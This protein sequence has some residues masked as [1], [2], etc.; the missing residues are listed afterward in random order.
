MQGF[1]RAHLRRH[2]PDPELRAKLMPDFE[3]ACKRILIS[4]DW[5]PALA[6]DNVD[7]VAA[8]VREVRGRTVIAN[9]GSAHDVDTIIFGTGFEVL[10]PPVAERIHGRG[11]RSLA[12]AWRRGLRHYRAVE[13]AGFPQLLPPRRRRLRPWPRQR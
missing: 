12:E 9:D 8:G 2:V 7:V 13:V 5:Y 10:A 11:G 1:A 6:Q 3:V 4:S